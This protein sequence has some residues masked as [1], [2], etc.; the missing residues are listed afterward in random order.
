MTSS[1]AE[2]YDTPASSCQLVAEEVQAAVDGAACGLAQSTQ[3]RQSH[4]LCEVA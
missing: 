3:R 1:S 2:L 4:D